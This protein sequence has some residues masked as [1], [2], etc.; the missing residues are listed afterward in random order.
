MRQSID[1]RIPLLSAVTF[2]V[3]VAI[4]TQ[5]G[6][7]AMA[8]AVG[9]IAVISSSTKLPRLGRRL[10]GL[11]V[12]MVF[13]WLL[14]PLE[15]KG[16]AILD[17]HWSTKGAILPARITLRANAILLVSTAL[18]D[19]LGM[20][21]MLDAFRRLHLPEPF[22]SLLGMSVRY[23]SLL[24]LEFQRLRVAMLSRGFRLRP[25]LQGYSAAA[26]ALGMLLVR[27]LD[28]SDRICR[29]MAARTF[30]PLHL[31][32]SPRFSRRDWLMAGGVSVVLVSLCLVELSLAVWT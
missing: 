8:L 25:T 1:P 17:W 11:N 26:M 5:W 27:S 2:A 4:S 28:R 10:I 23:L 16:P 6:T 9:V 31:P 7:L 29:A 19:P 30:G 13:F 21:G 14:L 12:M 24:R 20:L 22:P 3:V 18:L 32:P 15:W